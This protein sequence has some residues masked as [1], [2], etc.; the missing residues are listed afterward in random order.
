MIYEGIIN[1]KQTNKE[2]MNKEISTY[3]IIYEKDNE[4]NMITMTENCTEQ[5]DNDWIGNCEFEWD[6]ESYCEAKNAVRR[7]KKRIYNMNVIQPETEETI[8]DEGGDCVRQWGRIFG[9]Q[10]HIS[11]PV[12]G[13]GGR[14]LHANI[15]CKESR[16]SN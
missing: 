8:K 10:R 4:N 2:K 9:F 13:M 6:N 12:G 3:N 1:D 7:L 5:E 15:R 16:R 11:I 14:K